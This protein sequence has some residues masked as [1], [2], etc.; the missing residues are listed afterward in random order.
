MDRKK[1]RSDGF[2][3]EPD[4]DN[5]ASVEE[6]GGISEFRVVAA[7][8]VPDD[9]G[10]PIR[11]VVRTSPDA[12]RALAAPVPMGPPQE[13]SSVAPD[14][15]GADYLR[16]A[17]QS[18]R[19]TADDPYLAEEELT[20]HEGEQ[21]MLDAAPER[22]EREDRLVTSLPNRT[23]HEREVSELADEAVREV[24]KPRRHPHGAQHG[25]EREE[26][27]RIAAKRASDWN[28]L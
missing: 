27:A 1:K 26:E 13:S 3:P 18:P 4:R 25:E 5:R 21:R 20:L 23:E 7:S 19:T 6:L 15:L 22:A 11:S 9:E 28:K 2:P 24:E 16:G 14:E 10:D 17:V 12:D 8:D